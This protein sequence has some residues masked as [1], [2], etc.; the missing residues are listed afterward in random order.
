MNKNYTYGTTLLK[1]NLESRITVIGG[2]SGA[3]K[4]FLGKAWSKCSDDVIYVNY[5]NFV[6]VETLIFAIEKAVSGKIFILDNYDLYD[7]K[8]LVQSIKN[9]KASFLIFS[10]E[11]KYIRELDYKFAKIKYT[12]GVIEIK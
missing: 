1:I 5:S 11:R 6:D 3:G 2:D 7:S 9:S 4:S 12:K 10:R 8:S